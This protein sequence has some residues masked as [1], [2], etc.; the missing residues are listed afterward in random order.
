MGELTGGLTVSAASMCSSGT[1]D[2]SAP[3]CPHSQ[4]DCSNTSSEARAHVLYQK[5]DLDLQLLLCFLVAVVL[6]CKAA[7]VAQQTACK[8]PDGRCQDH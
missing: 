4:I 2:L 8:K 3:L 7:F 6:S 1:V 5:H